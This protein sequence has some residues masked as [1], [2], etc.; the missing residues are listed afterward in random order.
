MIHPDEVF[1]PYNQP[2]AVIYKPFDVRQLPRRIESMLVKEETS[3][4]LD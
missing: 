3:Q 1:P 4:D 2:D